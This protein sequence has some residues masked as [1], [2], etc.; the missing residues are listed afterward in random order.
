VEST[1]FVL[2]R[3]GAA[4]GDGRAYGQVHDPALSDAGRR[5]VERLRRRLGD[6][7][8]TAVVRSPARRAAE[9][10]AAL[11]QQHATIDAAFAE[12]HLGVWEGRPWSTIW[13]EV[14][15]T[16]QTDPVAYAAFTPDRAETADAV[17]DRVLTAWR[18]LALS[19]ADAD[20]AAPPLL[21]VTHAGPIMC[22]LQHAL[23]LDAATALRFRIATATATRVTAW[24]DGT[25]TIEG[26][27]T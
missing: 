9:T 25:T 27:A 21:V 13:D 26:V 20:P 8:F 12:R 16:V 4:D 10:A 6:E 23:G 1:R 17:R 22:V 18:A 3:H 2:V 7:R 24:A 19:Y 15:L 5:E 14:P 11:G